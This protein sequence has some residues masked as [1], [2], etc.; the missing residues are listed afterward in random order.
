[1]KVESFLG[2]SFIFSSQA[3]GSKLQRIQLSLGQ[4]VQALVLATGKDGEVLVEIGGRQ[5]WARSSIQ[6]W[7]GQ[8]LT[9][10][11]QALAPELVMRSISV[12]QPDHEALLAVCF[13][14]GLSLMSWEALGQLMRQ[15]QKEMDQ[16]G[17][18][19]RPESLGLFSEDS[20][21]AQTVH[22]NL[23]KLLRASGIFLE[24][25][26]RDI[27]L[28]KGD[29]G[30]I[31]PDLK[32]D[33]LKAIHE[34]GSSNHK[35][36]SLRHILDVL[37]GA[38]C[39]AVLGQERDSLQ[40]LASLPPWWM[41]KGSWGDLRIG[42]WVRSK[43]GV[44]KRGWSITLRMEME[45]MGKILAR[46]YLLGELL[47]CELKASREDVREMIQEEIKSLKDGLVGLWP[48]AVECWVGSL[49]ESL[50]WSEQELE[51][52]ESLVGVMA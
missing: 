12:F 29:I 14:K 5:I 19:S 4:V 1:M 43:G 2:S 18:V 36:G 7:P 23:E 31:F 16:A 41:P 3:S 11:V 13:K 26:L 15:A 28:G 50:D 9:L 33:L 24:A 10:Q 37:Q 27:V 40:L 20:S 32:A 51:L 45:D 48:T 46:V 44:L 21:P 35:E 6:T 25:K 22:W 8:I 34:L 39:L 17:L 30:S 38:Q 42:Q 49:D 52:P 47:G